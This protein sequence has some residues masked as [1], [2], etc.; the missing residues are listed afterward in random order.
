[1]IEVAIIPRGGSRLPGKNVR[2]IGGKPL[3]AWTVEAAL[4]SGCFRRVVVSTEDDLIAAAA[5]DAGAEIPF[6]RPAKLASDTATSI[7]VMLHALDQL[8]W[9]ASFALLQP[10]SPLRTSAHISQAVSKF[11]SSSADA[12]ISVCASKPASWLFEIDSNGQ[13][14][15][16]V[17]GEV[18]THSQ[19]AKPVYTP[20]G[21]IYLYNT[22]VFLDFRSFIPPG[23]TAFEMSPM[24]STDIDDFDDF[25]IAQIIIEQVQKLD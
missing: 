18:D 11:A 12:L 7:D 5:I 24:A 19:N 6:K 8:D 25:Q 4:C 14:S 10:T 13:L 2:V 9:P 22:Q 16:L 1:M 15:K 23:T 3:I 21:A 17:Q 20:N